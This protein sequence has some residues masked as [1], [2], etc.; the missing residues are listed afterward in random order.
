[1]SQV[2][3][4]TG[5]KD[6]GAAA[7]PS[8]RA[9]VPALDGVR[10]LAILIV[11]IHNASWVLAPSAWFPLKLIG[12]LTATGW[13]GVQLF[14]VLS[15]FLITSILLATRESAHYL[16]NFYVR[17]VLR[18][19]PLYYGFLILV[20][21]IGPWFASPEWTAVARKNQWWLWT[22]TSNWGGPLGHGVPYLPHFWSLA[23]EEQFY[24]MWPFLVLLLSRR[25]L[26]ALCV[27]TILVT[28]VIRLGLRFEGLPALAAYEFTTSRWDALAGGA[29]LSLLSAT[30]SGRA[31]LAKH[32]AP[33]GLVS[34]VALV[35]VVLATRGF[36][37]GE[38]LVQV[39]GQSL[40]VVLCAWLVYSACAPS[41]ALGNA[42][43]ECL[44][45]PWLRF[46]GKYSYAIYVFHV[47]LHQIA[48]VYIGDAVNGADSPWRMLRWALYVASIGG[49]SILAALAS[50]RLLEKPFLDLKDRFSA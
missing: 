37:E 47:P 8:S 36:R 15:G 23:V 12:A 29:L 6:D 1:M 45:A 33:L 20:F 32:L 28:P 13:V 18:I 9:R 41:S 49:A 30:D 3:V 4:G 11:V 31:R 39:I 19:F 50:W 34:L 35:T 27:A 2:R 10:G 38:F 48:S 5:F 24:L 22:F 43:Q 21:V 42:T 16:R 46:L 26:V 25:Q 14:F 7:V 40:T 44:S 17:R